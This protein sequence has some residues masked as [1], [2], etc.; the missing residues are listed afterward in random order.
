MQQTSR[1][2]VQDK[3]HLIRRKMINQD[4]GNRLKFDYSNKWY[5]RLIGI[6]V[7]ETKELEK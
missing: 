2:G 5:D 4:L 6:M 1:K 7:R 3:T